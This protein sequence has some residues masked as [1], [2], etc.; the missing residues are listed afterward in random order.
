MGVETRRPFDCHIAVSD[1][2]PGSGSGVEKRGRGWVVGAHGMDLG[3][4]VDDDISRHRL[5]VFVA[6]E[7]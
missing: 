3:V 4:E 5:G 2:A 1:M 6:W 7:V